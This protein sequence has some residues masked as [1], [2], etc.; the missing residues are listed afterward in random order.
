MGPKSQVKAT[1]LQALLHD[2]KDGFLPEVSNVIEISERQ[3]MYKS[4]SLANNVVKKK[5]TFVNAT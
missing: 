5:Q 3:Q 1:Q 2:K 4:F